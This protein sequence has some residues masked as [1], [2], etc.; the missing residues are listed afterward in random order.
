MSKPS[1]FD[2]SDLRASLQLRWSNES[3]R[4]MVKERL[5]VMSTARLAKGQDASP[6][7]GPKTVLEKAIAEIVFEIKKMLPPKPWHDT[8]RFVTFDLPVNDLQLLR[9]IQLLVDEAENDE[10]CREGVLSVAPAMR[11]HQDTAMFLKEIIF[12]FRSFFIAQVV[13]AVIKLD[14]DDGDGSLEKNPPKTDLKNE[15]RRGEED[16]EKLREKVISAS[17]AHA[18]AHAQNTDDVLYIDSLVPSRGKELSAHI[19]MCEKNGVCSRYATY[20]YIYMTSEATVTDKEWAKTMMPLAEAGLAH[21]QHDLGMCCLSEGDELQ[22]VA[23]LERAAKLGH[24]RAMLELAKFYFADALQWT[25]TA[26]KNKTKGSKVPSTDDIRQ[27]TSAAVKWLDTL[28]DSDWDKDTER[29]KDEA[30]KL[31]T[32]LAADAKR[33]KEYEAKRKQELAIDARNDRGPIGLC[34]RLFFAVARVFTLRNMLVSLV[35][36]ALAFVMGAPIAQ[37]QT[38]SLASR[39]EFATARDVNDDALE[40][41]ATHAGRY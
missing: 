12:P 38:P 37:P 5:R 15:I 3:F 40:D 18:A 20:N 22:G 4:Q 10:S 27:R 13:A 39:R 17:Q 11:K 26:S 35:I 33:Y 6:A 28:L 25:K 41:M 34:R 16:T 1:Q 9:W 30:R 23:W 36:V 32:S 19:K 2:V 29:D 21:A 24:T 14:V 7:A 8:I 31:L